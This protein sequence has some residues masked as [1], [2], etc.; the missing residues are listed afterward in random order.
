MKYLHLKFIDGG[1]IYGGNRNKSSSPHLTSVGLNSKVDNKNYGHDLN[2]LVPYTT[3]SNVLHVL[4]GKTPVPTKRESVLVRNKELDEIAL[5]SYIKY[6]T[7]IIYDNYNMPMPREIINT[8]KF[9]YNSE[10]KLNTTFKLF[11]GSFK[12]VRGHYNWNF[13]RRS[14]EDLKD[15]EF[16]VSLIKD[17]IKIDPLK[18][19]FDELIYELSKHWGE[20]DLSKY[21]GI[22]KY[23]WDNVI[24]NKH[25]TSS[26]LSYSSRT[27][28]FNNNGIAYKIR[29]GGE[30]ICQIENDKI[31]EDMC[32][33]GVTCA[34]FLDGGIIYILGIENYEPIP[35][36][37][38]IFT[39]IY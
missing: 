16:K 4:C 35:N 38:D 9:Q 15:F 13:F 3:L 20:L 32:N 5:N 37:K 21:N 7:K 33:D 2:N 11:D 29:I 8:N 17:I 26:N 31:I 23:G 30:I 28:I 18:L 25:S 14:C 10:K 12:T 34:T 19:T 36:F 39:K 24:L 27:P 22:F 6:D 1:L